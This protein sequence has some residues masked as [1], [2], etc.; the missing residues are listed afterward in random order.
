M[1]ISEWPLPWAFTWMLLLYK[2]DPETKMNLLQNV[3]QSALTIMMVDERT[4]HPLWIGL[5][6]GEAQ[7]KAE[8]ELVKK[9]LEYAIRK[10]FERFPR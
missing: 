5:A 1:Q 8:E 2:E 9:R 3:P 6:T 4:E 10:I 7:A